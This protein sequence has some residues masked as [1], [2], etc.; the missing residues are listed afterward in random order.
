MAVTPRL[1]GRGATKINGAG[2]PHAERTCMYHSVFDSLVDTE[3]SSP[4][5]VARASQQS[6]PAA[7][8]TAQQT[9][10]PVCQRCGWA[11]P[12]RQGPGSGPHYARLFCGAC[13]MFLQWTSGESPE[14]RQ[15]QV[16]FFRREAMSRQPATER[17][18]AYLRH[19][20]HPGPLPDNRLSAS[21]AID[22][23]LQARRRL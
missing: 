13:G 12:H 2:R 17:Q 10:A 9:H 6:A 20:G 16:E 7:A 22:R 15:A 23:L 3:K 14:E 21:E 4:F 1:R 8:T 19:L 11:G 18:L 5:G